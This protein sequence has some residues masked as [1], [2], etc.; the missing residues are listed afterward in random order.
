M[1]RRL[2]V[3]GA[4]MVVVAA[5]G[6]SRNAP[7]AP[8]DFKGYIAVNPMDYDTFQ[9]YG[10]S[11]VQFTTSAGVRCRIPWGSRSWQFSAGVDCWGPLPGVDPGVNLA[12]V[13]PI[14]PHDRDNSTPPGRNPPKDRSVY[15]LFSHT[16]VSAKEIYLGNPNEPRKTVDPASYHLL[17]AGQKIFIPGNRGGTRIDDALC[18]AGSDDLLICEVEKIELDDGRTHGFILSPRGSSV[19]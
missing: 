6:P 10:S 17:A 13:L 16:D 2:I 5:C 12:Q 7:T 1:I 14:A 9:S 11:G 19:Y 3:F 4:A 15:S 8:V 18:A